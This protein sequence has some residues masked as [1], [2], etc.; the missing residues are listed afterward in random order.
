MH[1]YGHTFDS[2]I[3]GWSYLLAI[4]IPSITGAE[5]TERRADRHAER[6][7]GN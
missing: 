3:F 2:Q 5:W 4:G 1:E 7:F 6:Y